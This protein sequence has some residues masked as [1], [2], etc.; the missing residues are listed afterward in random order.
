M[1]VRDRLSRIYFLRE[2]FFPL[3]HKQIK[4]MLFLKI[5]GPQ[6]PQIIETGIAGGHPQKG[7]N[8]RQAVEIG[9]QPVELDKRIG[10][11]ILRDFPVTYEPPG[12]IIYGRRA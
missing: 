2:F 10:R 6:V 8:S 3:L 4:E 12:E 5:P 11:N 1:L 7:L 9:M